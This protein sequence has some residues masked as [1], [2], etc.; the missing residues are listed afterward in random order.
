MPPTPRSKPRSAKITAKTGRSITPKAGGSKVVYA[1][2]ELSWLAF[3]R[4]V[5]EQARNEANPLLE[6]TKF[7]AIVSSNLDEFFEIRIAGLLQQKD[8]TGGEASLDG[9]SPR[10]QLKRAFTEIRRLVD[11]QYA[12]WHDLLVP[13]LA[14]EKITFK[15]A[16]QLS[17]A[18]R[19]WVHE[20]FA[21]QVHPVLTPLAIDQSHPFPQIANKTLNVI[22]TVDNPDT[23]EQESLTAVLP[24]P[25]ILP[26]LVQI[27][28]DK[29]GP[30]TFVF[31]SEII[32]LCAGDL[33]PGYHII[34]AQAFR[35]TRNSDLYIDDEE[36]DNLLKKIEEELR[37]LRRGAAVRLEIEDD[38]P[39][40][41]FQL[42]CENLQLDEERVFRLKGPLNLVRMMSL[43]DLV[44]RPDLKFP[45]FA[46]VESPLLKASP[47][48]FAS[49][50]EGDILLH[51]PYDSFNP[52][53][54]FVQQAA[55]DPGVL[56]I[57]Q[58]LYRTSG[59]SP[60]IGAL[61]EASRNGKQVT[62]LVELKARFDEANNIKWAK[63]LEEAGVHVVFG[64][65]GHKT[66]CKTSM[67]VRQ[68]PDGLR[69]YVHLGT[70]NYN[71][72]TARLY[73]DL[74]L[75]TCN[76]EIAAE[77]AQLFNSL[78]GFGRSPEFK[79]LL[80]APFNLHS[81]IQELIANEAA[82]AAAGKPARI[83][84][85]MN[86][87]VDKVTID[88]LYAASQAGV[89]IDLIV[90][91][92]CCLLPGVKGLSENIRVRNLVGRYLEHARIFYFE[93]AGAPLL[94]A[95]SSDWMPR[96]FF[97]RVE[98]LF[99]INTP[100]LRDRVLH[101][102]LPAELRDNVDARDLQSD[103]TYVAPARKEG[104]T[105]FSAQ[106]HFMADAEKRAAAQIEVVA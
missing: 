75:L 9:L 14:K 90:R 29:R 13:A 49:I 95:G 3:N 50:H 7:L 97:R 94:Y 73:T 91:A 82:N 46:P 48:I 99:P 16:S 41:V 64:L 31:L 39:A 56:A 87:L 55:R 89:Q 6:R 88:N 4:R 74:S 30:Q 65:V 35:V 8:S 19:T 67:V 77:V 70:G 78:T 11:D 44:D 51:H 23:P 18:E 1:N 71:P 28:P 32:K 42:L 36:A 27:T 105:D 102:I 37:N 63:E 80:V 53:V 66:H 85:K 59:D 86:K 79:H 68:E 33:F 25:R 62:A 106:N 21:K 54:E 83:I 38:A 81:R 92:T 100:A 60:I 57:K 93:N 96:N 47:S 103:G 72:K 26:R 34:S 24:V 2:R 45:V 43:S 58:T 20:Y 22:V 10:E 76:P 84:A 52:V 5:L 101:E 104:E 98:A 17:P 61:I 69:R 15:T 40:A 12:C